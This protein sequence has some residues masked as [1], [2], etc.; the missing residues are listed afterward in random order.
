MQITHPRFYLL[1]S[2]I[3]PLWILGF[4]RSYEDYNFRQEDYHV[5]SKYF[6]ICCDGCSTAATR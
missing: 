1:R 3:F 6:L 5:A 2:T 4:L